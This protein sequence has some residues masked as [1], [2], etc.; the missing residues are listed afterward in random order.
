MGPRNSNCCDLSLMNDAAG[1]VGGTKPGW[2]AHGEGSQGMGR[3]GIFK[4]IL[5][6]A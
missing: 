4:C 3:A 5:T 1:F 2:K 6:L